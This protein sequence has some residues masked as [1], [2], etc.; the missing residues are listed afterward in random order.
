MVRDK[1]LLI[2]GIINVC[3]IAV[4]WILLFMPGW[5][6]GF[7]TPIPSLYFVTPG[8]GINFY[9]SFFL[10]PSLILNLVFILSKE[11]NTSGK[12]GFGL[13]VPGWILNLIG[14]ITG[15]LYMFY[16][17]FISPIIILILDIFLIV[18]GALLF[19]RC[20]S[21]EVLATVPNSYMQYSSYNSSYT[22]Q[23]RQLGPPC[24]LCNREQH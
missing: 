18:S 3:L 14:S 4:V 11:G 12:V 22:L 9:G 1:L 17:T 2:Y 15:I 24:P 7:S 16:F 21:D 20:Y 19:S 6:A 5:Y 23:D 10:V 8:G 13:G